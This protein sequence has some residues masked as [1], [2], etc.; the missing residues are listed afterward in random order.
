MIDYKTLLIH[1]IIGCGVNG[2]YDFCGTMTK[3]G[4]AYFS[5]N[6]WNEDWSWKR[7]A[8][9]ELAVPELETIYLTVKPK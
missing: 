5:G 3:R 7:E 4:L 9:Q 2:G 1:A 8:L 6:Q